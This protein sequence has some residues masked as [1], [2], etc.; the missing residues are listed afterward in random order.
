MIKWMRNYS[1]SGD[2][3]PLAG[4][5][6]TEMSERRG[7]LSSSFNASAMTAFPPLIVSWEPPKRFVQGISHAMTH[8]ID[9][10]AQSLLVEEMSHVGRH[11][12]IRVWFSMWRCPVIPEV[13]MVSYVAFKR[14]S[15]LVCISACL[16]SEQRS[17]PV[18]ASSALTHWK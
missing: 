3:L 1:H 5:M 7:L 8:E 16:V 9:A 15:L 13:L 17:L 10:R 14:E 12:G 18:I 4:D 6:S 11:G 2:I